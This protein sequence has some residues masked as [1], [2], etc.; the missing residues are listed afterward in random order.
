MKKRELQV[1]LLGKCTFIWNGEELSLGGEAA[2]KPIQLLQMLL[3]CRSTGITRATAIENLFDVQGQVNPVNNLRNTRF[4]LKHL[5]ED[6]GMPPCE[7]VLVRGSRLYWNPE[8]PFALDVEVFEKAAAKAMKE[9]QPERRLNAALNACSLFAGR[10]LPTQAALPWVA[11]ENLRLE[12]IFFDLVRIAGQALEEKG[13]C[14]AAGALYERASDIAPYEEEWTIGV[15]RCMQRTGR[16]REA[17]ARYEKAVGVFLDEFGVAPS[18]EFRQCMDDAEAETGFTSALEIRDCI[19]QGYDGGA[20]FCHFAEFVHYCS[21]VSRLDARSGRATSLIWCS[22][23]SPQN[24]AGDP[25]QRK[26]RMTAAMM[27]TLHDTLRNSDVFTRYGDSQYLILLPGSGNENSSLVFER[28]NNRFKE[29]KAAYG[30][31][32]SLHTVPLAPPPVEAG[33]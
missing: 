20:Y 31:T 14:E 32:L 30:Y 11:L 25:T 24:E 1:G 26:S 2:N 8:V 7:Y 9:K 3:Y 23:I 13:D 33:Q 28:L 5:L 22:V 16:H 18:E 21:L 10:L 15:I 27:E 12:K 19:A 29:Q 4:R 17:L 6:A